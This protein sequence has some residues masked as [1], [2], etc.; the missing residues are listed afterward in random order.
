MY[1]QPSQ[2]L[3][4]ANTITDLPDGLVIWIAQI[5][6]NHLKADWSRAH[7]HSNAQIPGG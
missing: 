6:L 2:G 7:L 1:D 3:L 5:Q 4:F